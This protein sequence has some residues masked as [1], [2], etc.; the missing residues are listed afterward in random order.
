MSG[1]ITPEHIVLFGARILRAEC[2]AVEVFDEALHREIDI[3]AVTLK[4]CQ[5]GAA[6]AAPQISI[7]KRITVI[8]YMKQ[9]LELVNPVIL[10]QSGSVLDFEGCLSMPSWSGRVERA[11]RVKVRYQDRHGEF[12]EMTAE[13]EMAR[14]LQHEI[15]HLEGIL[16]ID[17]MTDEF[18]LNFET[19]EGIDVMKLIQY[20]KRLA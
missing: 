17:R 15:D 20:T 1:D 14:C 6:L 4:A 10:E 8:D 19:E 5:G 7:R 18:V 9:Y 12:H 2:E 13:N 3:M 11:R 16:Y